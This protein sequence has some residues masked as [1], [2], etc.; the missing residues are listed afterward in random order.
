MRTIKTAVVTGPTG[1]VGHALCSRLLNEGITTFAVCRP[2]S[3]RVNTLPHG[4][5]VIN[6]D[7]S[8]LSSLP[9]DIHSADAFFHLAWVGTVGGGR[10]DKTTQKKNVEYA[11]NACR[12]A[13]EI[14]CSVFIGAG[15]QAEYGRHDEPLRPDT[16]CFPD[17]EYGKAKL[18]AGILCRTECEKLGIDMIWPRILSVY[19]PFDSEKTLIISAVRKL[20]SG[21]SPDLTE[22]K[23]LWDYLYSDDAADALLLLAK[24]GRNGRVYP[25]GSGSARQLK[26]YVEMIRDAVD[27]SIPLKFG[28]I[29]YGKNQVMHLEADITMLSN[30]TGFLPN[31]DFENGIRKTVE[32]VRAH[33]NG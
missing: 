13:V 12:A 14:G 19:G 30:D 25:I 32:Y 28:T 23:Q 7:I 4:V 24:N 20:L 33:K 18:E 22:G 5:I 1:A 27:S 9:G 10:N 29:P 26:E 17:N 11:L 6:R 2:G 3:P 8:E 21:E 15:S 31:T 16:P